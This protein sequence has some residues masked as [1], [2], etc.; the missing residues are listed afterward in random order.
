M[1]LKLDSYNTILGESKEGNHKTGMKQIRVFTSAEQRPLENRVK[2]LR[3]FIYNQFFPLIGS[4]N[5][6]KL[7]LTGVIF[8]NLYG[9]Q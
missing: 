1:Q 2:K 4:D 8:I 5:F 6:D 3:N 9:I 7:F